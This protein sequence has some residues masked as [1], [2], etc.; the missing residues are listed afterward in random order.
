MIIP[1]NFVLSTIVFALSLIPESLLLKVGSMALGNTGDIK[2]RNLIRGI[3]GVY[4]IKMIAWGS[5][6]VWCSS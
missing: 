3:S 2:R 5:W 6:Q 1:Y 4:L